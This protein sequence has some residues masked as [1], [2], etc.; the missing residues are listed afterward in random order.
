MKKFLSLALAML[1]AFA[2][3]VPAFAD[4]PVTN[5]DATVTINSTNN[6]NAKYEAYKLLDLTTRFTCTKD[7]HT[8]DDTCGEEGNYTCGK[9]AHTHND[10]EC[11]IYSYTVSNTYKTELLSVLNGTKVAGDEGYIA[12]DD[13]ELDVKVYNVLSAMNAGEIRSFANKMIEVLDGKTATVTDIEQGKAAELGQGYWLIVDVSSTVTGV[14][15][16]LVMLDTKGEKKLTITAKDSKS[17]FEKEVDEENSYIGQSKEFT[18]SYVLPSNLDQYKSY[19]FKVTDTLQNDGL[20]FVTTSGTY[21]AKVGSSDITANANFAFNGNKMT[22]D[23]G[24]YF[25]ANKDTVKG[26]AVTIKY[27][28][29]VTDAAVIAGDGNGNGAKLEITN[30]PSKGSTG[31]M[32]SS[33]VVKTYALAIKKINEKGEP[34]ADAYFQF[35]FYVKANPATDGAYI[36]AGTIEGDGLI[37]EIP[38]NDKGEIIVKGVK[39]GTYK[40]VIETKAPKGYNKLVDPFDV[41]AVETSATS[42]S[43]KI[44]LDDN[45][46][47]VDAESATIT[48]EVNSGIP[49]TVKPVLNKTGFE[50]PSTGGVGTTIFYAVGG[51][52]MAGAAILLITRKK[53]SNEE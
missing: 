47:V 15:K 42:T 18:L 53:M 45:G 3:T 23:L 41:T 28:V 43:E 5:D 7:E 36:Y 44:Y 10:R 21:S 1:M 30:D 4:E 39:A 33:D 52:M 19:T 49:V 25:F 50:L 8:H 11:Y 29:K 12:A 2:L 24:D 6:E 9:T 26:E 22:L 32:E 51:L 35:P 46:N 34:L 13:K 38:T 37:N 27:Q 31:T 17:T 20:E 14:S 48:T 40:D 16:S